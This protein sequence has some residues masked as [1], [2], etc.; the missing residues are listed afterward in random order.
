M[1]C[2]FFGAGDEFDA[3]LGGTFGVAVVACVLGVLHAAAIFTFARSAGDGLFYKC[4][5]ECM[6]MNNETNAAVNSGGGG[7]GAALNSNQQQPPVPVR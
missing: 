3:K 6:A 5:H 7:G 2:T 1:F 4:W